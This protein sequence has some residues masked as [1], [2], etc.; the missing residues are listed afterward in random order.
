MSCMFTAHD[1]V[2]WRVTW[3]DRLRT[4]S[5]QQADL[6]SVLA[7]YTDELYIFGELFFLSFL[8]WSLKFLL[9][10][11]FLESSYTNFYF[12]RIFILLNGKTLLFPIGFRDITLTWFWSSP[13]APFK[14]SWPASL[15]PI[16]DSEAPKHLILAI[17]CFSIYMLSLS[18]LSQAHG[19]KYCLYA[20]D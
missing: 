13:A 5:W 7:L 11:L 1:M 12:V 2:A 14:A 8:I 16:P 9:M 20:D 4:Q 6:V 17:Y 3:W 10:P 15:H 19:F 18:A